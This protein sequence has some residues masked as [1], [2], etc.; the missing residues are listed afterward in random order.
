MVPNHARL[1]IQME[2]Q[3]EQILCLPNALVSKKFNFAATELRLA[4]MCAYGTDTQIYAIFIE[5]T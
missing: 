1:H 4:Q 2:A 3:M 5:A